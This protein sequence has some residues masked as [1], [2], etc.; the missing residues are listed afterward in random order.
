MSAV[1]GASAV[2]STG[3][4]KRVVKHCAAHSM[5]GRASGG[6]QR[7]G[8]SLTALVRPKKIDTREDDQGELKRTNE[9]GSV[10]PLLETVELQ[11][12]DL[13]A[14]ALHTQH[15]L[16][17]DIELL[18]AHRGAPA[19]T[20]TDAGHGRI[21]T[22]NLWT[23]TALNAHVNFPGV[24]QV[25]LIESD[26]I[27]KKTGKHS[28]ELAYCVTNRTPQQ[29]TPEQLLQLNRGHWGIE[30]HHPILDVTYATGSMST[31]AL[32]G[33]IFLRHAQPT[34][35]LLAPTAYPAITPS[36]PRRHNNLRLHNRKIGGCASS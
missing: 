24:Q 3:G 20:S 1:F 21:E 28:N 36:H 13:T 18:F 35:T 27:E 10:I 4:S 7:G 25:M 30:A 32:T 31:A 14:D 5:S 23:S 17:A 6:D 33:G 34:K 29:K 16:K 11:G 12:R 15:T 19:F 22:R 9:I 26:V 2:F 8:S